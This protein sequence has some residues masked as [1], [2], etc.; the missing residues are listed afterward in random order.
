VSVN[1]ACVKTPETEYLLH[2]AGWHY[3]CEARGT[4][5]PIEIVRLTVLGK[6]AASRKR[7]WTLD[8]EAI[9][10]VFDAPVM[11]PLDRVLNH[12]QGCGVGFSPPAWVLRS[13]APFGVVPGLT[14]TQAAIRGEPCRP[15]RTTPSWSLRFAPDGCYPVFLKVGAYPVLLGVRAQSEEFSMKH[16]EER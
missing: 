15:F 5:A 1:A 11:R 4:D 2:Q 6:R 10:D 9:G 14:A 16:P 13:A 12:F 3:T 7:A 8:T